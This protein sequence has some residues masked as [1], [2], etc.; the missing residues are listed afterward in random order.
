MQGNRLK[1]ATPLLTGTVMTVL[2]AAPAFAGDIKLTE[3]GSS[4]LY[5]LFTVWASEYGKTHPGVQITAASTGSG[6]GIDQALAGQVQI[7]AS[8]A[9]MSDQQ[10]RKNPEILNIP[11][12]I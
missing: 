10:A 6:A 3:T 4:L 7:G 1:W 12:A 2:V 5:P 9:Y 8:D 11:L